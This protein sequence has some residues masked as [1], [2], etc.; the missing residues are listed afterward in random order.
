MSSKFEFNIFK[1]SLLK[2][3][4]YRNNR[5]ECSVSRSPSGEHFISIGNCGGWIH[6]FCTA[7]IGDDCEK[8]NNCLCWE[9]EPGIFRA[10]YIDTFCKFG[11]IVL[12]STS[13]HSSKQKASIYAIDAWRNAKREIIKIADDELD[14]KRK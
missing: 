9:C 11:D 12:Y 14:M 3:S 13:T 1:S 8:V 5:L 6:G 7:M 2:L 10:V 4:I